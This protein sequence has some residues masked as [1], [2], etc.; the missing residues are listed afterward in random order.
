[1]DDLYPK[2]PHHQTNISALNVSDNVPAGA[3]PGGTWQTFPGIGD[4]QYK[5]RVYF[6]PGV[7]MPKPRDDHRIYIADVI[8]PTNGNRL[9]DSYDR[10]P[11]NWRDHL[12]QGGPFVNGQQAK[13]HSA[14]EMRQITNDFITKMARD[15]KAGLNF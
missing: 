12:A 6:A 1:M 4:T 11:L 10:L 7:Q 3:Q 14:E 15:A 9:G 5:D 13:P 8:D 2:I